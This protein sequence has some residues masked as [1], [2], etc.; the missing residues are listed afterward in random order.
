MLEKKLDI[1]YVT[2]GIAPFMQIEEPSLLMKVFSVV[3][4]LAIM[5]TPWGR[6]IADYNEYFIKSPE[7]IDKEYEEM[8]KHFGIDGKAEQYAFHYVR[9]IDVGVYMM[10][11][12]KD[13]INRQTFETNL[14]KKMEDCLSFINSEAYYMYGDKVDPR[15]TK[16]AYEWILNE[17]N[18][19]LEKDYEVSFLNE[20]K[21]VKELNDWRVNFHSR[22]TAEDWGNRPNVTVSKT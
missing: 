17:I 1:V 15:F 4:Y 2:K 8:Y 19:A 6:V 10:F 16:E 9:G 3:R 14:E 12:E 13:E 11:P 18:Q 21:I 20:I 7:E 5:S 22:Y